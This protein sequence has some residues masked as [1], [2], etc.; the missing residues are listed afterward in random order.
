MRNSGKGFHLGCFGRVSVKTDPWISPGYL[1]NRILQAWCVVTTLH[2]SHVWS[3]LM[4]SCHPVET[5]AAVAATLTGLLLS[6]WWIILLL[7]WP[8]KAG[9]AKAASL[10]VQALTVLLYPFWKK[11][12]QLLF[13][14]EHVQSTLNTIY[15]SRCIHPLHHNDTDLSALKVSRGTR[16]LALIW[17]S[18]RGTIADDNVWGEEKKRA[19]S[20][21]SEKNELCHSVNSFKM[22]MRNWLCIS[23]PAVLLAI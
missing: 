23:C 13:T 21:Y 14:E 3:A 1:F 2:R 15:R 9:N 5:A 18:F 6:N 19:T 10:C 11:K 8:P 22:P 17:D 12:I 16:G 7:I 4:V 20:S